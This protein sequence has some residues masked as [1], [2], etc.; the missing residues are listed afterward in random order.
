MTEPANQAPD[1]VGGAKVILY[2]SIERRRATGRTDHVHI[3]KSVN[4]TIGLAICKYENE[5]GYYLF[6]C[7]SNWKSVADTW[8]ETVE[9]AIEQAEWEYGDLSGAWVKK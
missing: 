3:G 2:A 4:P 9:E 5:D 1:I 7:D 6:G 8:H